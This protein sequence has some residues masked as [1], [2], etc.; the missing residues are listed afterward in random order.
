M[1]LR[2]IGNTQDTS[3]IALQEEVFYVLCSVIG[4]SVMFSAAL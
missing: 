3:S 2:F 4:K 1:L